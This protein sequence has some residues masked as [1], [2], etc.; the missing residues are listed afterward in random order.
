MG[1]STHNEGIIPA[2]GGECRQHV[3]RFPQQNVN[4]GTWEASDAGECLKPLEAFT[5][6][7]RI[8][9]V[10]FAVDD[11]DPRMRSARQVP[12]NSQNI[13]REP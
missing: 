13:A 5:V 6:L 11:I 10:R 8:Y 12:T 1:Q 9:V 2:A 4:T 3:I 7:E